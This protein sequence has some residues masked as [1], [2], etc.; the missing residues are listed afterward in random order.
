MSVRRPAPTAALRGGAVGATTATL[1]VAAHGIGGGGLPDS[2]TLTLLLAA[3]AGVGAAVGGVP[4]LSRSLWALLAALAAGQSVGHLALTL[5]PDAHVHSGVPAL[6][7]L[8][9]H[10]AATVVCAALIL[11]AERLYGPI[12]AVLRAALEPPVLGVDPARSLRPR[13]LDRRAPRL[14]VLAAG[15]S[16]R[17]PPVFA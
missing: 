17:G 7:M 9:A 10:A 8:A 6:A 1:A 12:T 2:A 13:P 3:C 16:R 11:T 4:V 14:T 5:A 15:L